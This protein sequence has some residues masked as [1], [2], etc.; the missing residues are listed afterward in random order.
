VKLDSFHLH[1]W[2][3]ELQNLLLEEILISVRSRV[4][5]TIGSMEIVYSRAS[6]RAVDEEAGMK[7]SRLRRVT[8]AIID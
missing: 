5:A 3:G 2:N 1:A 7:R 8:I 4:L 6:W